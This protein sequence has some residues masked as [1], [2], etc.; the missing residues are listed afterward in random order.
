MTGELVTYRRE[1]RISHITLNRPDKLNAASDELVSDLADAFHKFD[2]DE[3]AWVAILSGA[4]TSFCSGADVLQRQN[5]SQEEFKRLGGPEA[6]NAIGGEVLTRS[7]NWKPVIAAVHGY[8]LGLGT[9]WMLAADYIVAADDTKLQLTETRRGLSSIAL[10]QLMRYRGAGSFADDV[11]ITGRYFSGEEAHHHHVIDKLVP[12]GSHLDEARQVAE[13]VL[14]NPPLAVRAI[15][16]TRRRAI[17]RLL[18]DA[19]FDSAPLHL[20]LS[21]DFTES[22]RAWKERRPPNPFTAR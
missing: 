12:A 18:R 4:G 17:D 13:E 2:T 16:R 11:G 15:V 20:Y 3:E 5:R 6:R 8:V 22:A 10:V 9:Q 1:G 21:E 7:I 14:K 19:G